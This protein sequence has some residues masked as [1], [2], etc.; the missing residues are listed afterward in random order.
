M[1]YLAKLLENAL[2]TRYVK[3]RHPEVLEQLQAIVEAA[4]LEQ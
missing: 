1:R 4:S 3:Q 2:V